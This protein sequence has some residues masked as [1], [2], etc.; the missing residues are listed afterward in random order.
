MEMD[1]KEL[2]TVM[3]HYRDSKIG[4]CLMESLTEMM[5]SGILVFAQSVD[6]F[7]QFDKGHLH[8]YN[9]CQSVW[10]FDLQDAVLTN[11]EGKQNVPR[12]SILALDSKAEA[13]AK[14]L[15]L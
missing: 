13:K 8:S 10:R 11:E 3:F 9:Y 4:T 12:I 5:Q 7:N 15:Q 1:D 6:I 14:A 2:M